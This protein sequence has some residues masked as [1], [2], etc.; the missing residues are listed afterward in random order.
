MNTFYLI[1]HG[2]KVGEAGDSGLTELGKIQAEKTAEFLNDK[3][4]F[5]IYSSTFARAKETAEI[6]NK[7]LKVGIVFDDRLRERMNWGSVPNQTLEEFLKEWEYSNL[8]RE[9]KPKAGISSL[10]SGKDAL[11]VISEISTFFPNSNIAIITHGGVICDLL[12]NI[13]LDSELIKLQPDFPEKLDR[14]IKECSITILNKNDDKYSLK[15][16]G[17]VDHLV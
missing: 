4:I 3:K 1:R 16:I 12:R 8:H 17:A 11:N 2:Q 9:F 10:Q 6:I 7:T 5:K 14:L 13:F 15:E